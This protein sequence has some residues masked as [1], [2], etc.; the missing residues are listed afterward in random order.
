M[1]SP[2]RNERGSVFDYLQF[3]SWINWQTNHF[4]HLSINYHSIHSSFNSIQFYSFWC[5]V[6]YIPVNSKLLGE[7]SIVDL[8]QLY[9]VDNDDGSSSWLKILILDDDDNNIIIKREKERKKESC[10]GF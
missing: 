10:Y 4:G 8:I 9:S 2:G 6:K 1:T 5:L 3:F 7:T